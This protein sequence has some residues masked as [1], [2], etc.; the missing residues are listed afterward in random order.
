MFVDDR[1]GRHPCL[2]NRRRKARAR[3][4]HIALLSLRFLLED[5]CVSAQHHP[6]INVSDFAFSIKDA[7]SLYH[8]DSTNYLISV[9]PIPSFSTLRCS[10]CETCLLLFLMLLTGK[11]QPSSCL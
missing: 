5:Y 6:L 10:P 2:P 3:L 4:G 7:F 9:L 11:I 1:Q 8:R